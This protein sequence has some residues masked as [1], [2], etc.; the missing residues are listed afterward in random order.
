MQLIEECVTMSAAA[1]TSLTSSLTLKSEGT[2]G[3]HHKSFRP[4]RKMRLQ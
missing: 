4:L 1:A 2:E 3:T